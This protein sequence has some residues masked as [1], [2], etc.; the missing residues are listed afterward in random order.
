MLFTVLRRMN[1]NRPW[2][3]WP[4]QERNRSNLPALRKRYAKELEALRQEQYRFFCQW[5]RLKRYAEKLGI[6]LI[7]DLPIYAAMDGADTWA[8]RELFQ[9]DAQG[10]PTLR[11]GCPPDYFTPEGQ[12]WGNPAL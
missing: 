3:C 10:Y 7:G 8:H 5:N 11:A 6:A 4:E 2:Q 9:L 12:D 1:E